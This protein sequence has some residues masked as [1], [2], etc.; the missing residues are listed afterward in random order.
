MLESKEKYAVP[1]S[2]QEFLTIDEFKL[3]MNTECN[4]EE[5]KKTKNL[6]ALNLVSKVFATPQP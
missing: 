5:V 2:M 3:L 6:N 4:N 1:E